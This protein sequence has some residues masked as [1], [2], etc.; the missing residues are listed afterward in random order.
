MTEDEFMSLKPGD[1]VRDVSE[2]GISWIMLSA[3]NKTTGIARVLIVETVLGYYDDV[4]LVGSTQF[5]GRNYHMV[6]R[7]TA[8]IVRE[9]S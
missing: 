3:P 9:A 7:D 2:Y 5:F 6:R 4:Y 1:L 8:K